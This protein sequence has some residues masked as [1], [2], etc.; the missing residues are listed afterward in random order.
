MP[1]STERPKDISE[2][3]LAFQD[4]TELNVTHKHSLIAGLKELFASH[5][6]DESVF[7]D[8]FLWH[9]LVGS[10]PGE[11]VVERDVEGGLIENFLDEKLKELGL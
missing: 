4:N 6:V 9:E 7:K 3:I 2:R 8:T 1:E 11:L 10:T 5:G